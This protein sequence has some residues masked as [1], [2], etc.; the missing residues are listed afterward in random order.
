MKLRRS[1]LCMLAG[2]ALLAGLA[3]PAL[4]QVPGARYQPARPTISPYLNLL[5]PDDAILPDYYTFVRPQLQTEAY[6]AQQ[7]IVNRQQQSMLFQQQA[8]IEQV[9]S[10]T[11]R[12][13]AAQVR[14]T[15][16][17]SG[18]MN[19]SHY[20]PLPQSRSGKGRSR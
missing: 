10:G 18:F 13:R 17:A 19:T 1:A 4:A 6:R 12:T 16:T 9:A 8:E 15:G 7:S 3:A 14:P 5:R 20:F 11:F 2:L